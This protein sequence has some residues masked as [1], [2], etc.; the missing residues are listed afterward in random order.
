MAVVRSYYPEFTEDQIVDLK[1]KEFSSWLQYYVSDGVSKGQSFPTWL[2]E[3]SNGPNY[4]A[5][6][7]PRYC[8]RG[9]AFR[10]YEDGTRRTTT[11]SGISVQAGGVVYYGILREIL[12]IRYPGML[13]MRCIAFLCDWY[14]PV[15]GSGVRV[16]QFGVTS[17]DSRRRLLKYDPFIL[18]SQADQVCYI[19]YPRVTRVNDPWITVTSVNPRGQVYGVA[20]HEPL[21]ASRSCQMASVEHSLEV[22]LM[23]DFTLFEDEIVHSESEESVGEFDDDIDSIPSDYSTDSE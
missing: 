8:T 4:I 16:D 15:V 21:Q 19:N 17:I 6:S 18:A 7:Y 20:A 9:Y 10:I 13:N 5:K 12:E 23:V 3:F 2:L 22:D 1:E 14:D 11:D